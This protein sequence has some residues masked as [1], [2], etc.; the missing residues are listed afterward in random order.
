MIDQ[1]TSKKDRENFEVL[2]Q[3]SPDIASNIAT[4]RSYMTRMKHT[5]MTP[6]EFVRDLANVHQITD[7]SSFGNRLEDVALNSRFDFAGDADGAER[8]DLERG[9]LEFQKTKHKEDQKLREEQFSMQQKLRD[10]Q[11]SHQEKLDRERLRISK[12]QLGQQRKRDRQSHSLAERQFRQRVKDTA[13][14]RSAREI[15]NNAQVANIRSGIRNRMDR[16]TSPYGTI[17]QHRYL[18]ETY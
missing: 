2:Q 14:D 4:A 18:K 1:F 7:R 10:K 11:F 5:S 3:F 16:E 9:K 12:R 6:H 8:M 17:A 15:L 13:Q